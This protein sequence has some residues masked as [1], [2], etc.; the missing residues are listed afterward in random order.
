MPAGIP[1]VWNTAFAMN[2]IESNSGTHKGET[3]ML[4]PFIATLVVFFAIDCV[5]AL[6]PGL[7]KSLV[8]LEADFQ[9]RNELAAELAGYPVHMQLE[10]R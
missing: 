6:G 2:L 8:K 5:S 3:T 1:V 10:K 7:G 4:R 9:A